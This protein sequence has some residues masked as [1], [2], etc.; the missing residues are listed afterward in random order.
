[1]TT[2]PLPRFAIVLAGGR[3]TRMGVDKLA[4]ASIAGTMLY[5]TCTAASRW[6]QRMVVAG[7]ARPGD[8]AGFEFCV[9]DPPFG[10]PVAGIAV[11]LA[12][13]PDSSDG[14]V[15]VLAGDLS[16]P[17]E[18]V[19][20]LAS[21]E[22]GPDGVALADEEGRAQYLAARYRLESLRAAL[23]AAPR[24]R[25]IAVWRVLSPLDLHLV[26]AA[27][28]LIADVDTPEV[29]RAAGFDVPEHQ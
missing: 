10:G 12:A 24:T 6:A 17:D 21:A 7:P 2:T 3:S 28:G 16:R 25:D 29:A 14:E 26:P 13:L 19:A 8:T 11:A 4:L 9:E 15:L 20:K 18:V 1:M 27:G 5:R 22:I 23:S